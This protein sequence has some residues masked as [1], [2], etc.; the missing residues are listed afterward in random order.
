MRQ[1]KKKTLKKPKPKKPTKLRG[2]KLKRWK[3][4]LETLEK[5][6]ND[7]LEQYR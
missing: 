2:R 4:H 1:P 3:Q 7:P 5:L 6:A